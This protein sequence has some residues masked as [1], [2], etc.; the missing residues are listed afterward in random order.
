MYRQLTTSWRQLIKSWRLT[1]SQLTA[2][3]TAV[4]CMRLCC[5]PCTWCKLQGD[6]RALPNPWRCLGTAGSRRAARAC[7]G[8]G[9]GIF[10]AAPARKNTH[11]NEKKK[12]HRPA[13]TEKAT[14]NKHY[15]RGGG[16]IEQ[17]NVKLK[18]NKKNTKQQILYF[19]K[20]RNKKG[21]RQI[22]I[23]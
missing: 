8:A 3:E 5:V 15:M 12:S 11:N 18:T 19:D 14:P 1:V 4:S 2:L 20:K 23:N 6:R 13:S 16:S 17:K 10:P 7:Q 21:Q 22:K 9:L